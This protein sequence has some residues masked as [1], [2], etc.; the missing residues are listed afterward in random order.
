[1]ITSFSEK[2]V[3]QKSSILSGLAQHFPF[4]FNLFSRHQPQ[5]NDTQENPS[6]Q[7]AFPSEEID[8]P[9]SSEMG[10]RNAV[11]VIAEG[12]DS[13]SEE[14]QTRINRNYSEFHI[15]RFILY[16]AFYL[17]LLKILFCYA[18]S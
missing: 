1:M 6:L 4:F 8:S 13:Y 10:S 12:F 9:D 16:L 3:S 11:D 18:K 7:N 14:P 5:L 2:Q 15:S 17:V